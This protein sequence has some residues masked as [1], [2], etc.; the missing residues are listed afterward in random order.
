MDDDVDYGDASRYVNDVSIELAWAA[1]AY[2]R[3][4]VHMNLLMSCKTDGLR[5][6]REHDE[7]YQAFRAG[8][9]DLDVQAITEDDLKSED[10]KNRWREFCDKFKEVDDFNLGT[11]LRKDAGQAYT[12]NN[13]IIA[14]K[15][16]FLAIEGAR[17]REG[18]NERN[19]ESYIA[20]YKRSEAVAAS[21][22]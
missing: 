18:I 11:L 9:P 14:P 7:V 3:A 15:I 22:R 16:I 8:W 4:G 13:C 2:E 5:L 12:E 21:M 20:D 17:N 10:A 19:K 1:K 6:H